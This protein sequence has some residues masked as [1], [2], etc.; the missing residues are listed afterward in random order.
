MNIRSFLLHYIKSPDQMSALEFNYT[1]R[2]S[3][4]SSSLTNP[5][6]EYTKTLHTWSDYEKIPSPKSIHL[7]SYLPCH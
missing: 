5:V 7:T 6:G 1:V 4:I 3:N 2:L